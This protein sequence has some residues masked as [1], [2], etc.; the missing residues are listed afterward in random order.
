VVTG[1][2][3]FGAPLLPGCGADNSTET[4]IPKESPAE[5]GKDSMDYYRNQSKQAKK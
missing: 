2:T 4:V 3:V 5:K 1:L